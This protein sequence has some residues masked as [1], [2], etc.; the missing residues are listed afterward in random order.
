V[1][2]PP[3]DECVE[4]FSPQSKGIG[5]VVAAAAVVSRVAVVLVV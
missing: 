1:R 4:G 5:V 2:E 3:R